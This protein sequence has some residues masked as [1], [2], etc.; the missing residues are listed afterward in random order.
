M[1]CYNILKGVFGHLQIILFFF[2]G[3][4]FFIKLTI[5]ISV[6]YIYTKIWLI[7]D[8]LLDYFGFRRTD[9]SPLRYFF[10]KQKMFSRIQ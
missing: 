10:S 4:F 6:I 5:K 8:T 9:E 2:L 3:E 7:L 1:L